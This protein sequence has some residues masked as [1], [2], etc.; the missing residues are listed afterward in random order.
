MQYQG[1]SAEEAARIFIVAEIGLAQAL[2]AATG[3][4]MPIAGVPTRRGPTGSAAG[5]VAPK[6]LEPVGRQVCIPYRMSDILVTK[7]MLERPRIVPLVGQLVA[8]G[9]PEHVRVHREGQIGLQSC[10]GDKLA[11]V[12]R[13]H[14]AATLGDKQ[15]GAVGP[16]TSKLAQR[17][18]FGTT[19]GVRRGH[20][21][22]QALD[23]KKA[24]FQVKLL[25]T[26]ADSLT[27]AQSMA[28][29]YKQ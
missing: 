23:R 24:G 18:Q 27:D 1:D 9:V 11:D 21:L 20:T 25:P 12:A 10:T 4:G 29:H 28:I 2:Q 8:A 26:Q 16:L 6:P 7:V 5:S 19:Q 17:P 22:L 3:V 15:V 13:R 14:W